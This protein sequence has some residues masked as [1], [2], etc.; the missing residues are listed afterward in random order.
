VKTNIDH[1]HCGDRVR[2]TEGR[3]VAR[4][5]AISNGFARIR[6]ED[7]GW[8]SDYPTEDLVVLKSVRWDAD[9]GRHVRDD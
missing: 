9:I 7:S 4:L 6:W 1:L 3:H 5:E 8:L 2:E